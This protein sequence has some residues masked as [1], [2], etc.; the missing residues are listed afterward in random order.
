MA[1]QVE[2]NYEETNQRRKK[3]ERRSM[4]EAI[5]ITPNS[6]GTYGQKL[7]LWLPACLHLLC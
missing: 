5:E 4:V 7:K 6:T 3:R 2:G 1:Y